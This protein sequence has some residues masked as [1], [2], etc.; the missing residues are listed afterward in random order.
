MELITPGIGLIFWQTVTF[1]LVLFLLGKFAWKPI[2]ASLSE[3]ED[4][5]EQALGAAA[6]AK[7]EM[8]LL[9]AENEN[10]L[11]QARLEKDKIIKE[12]QAVAVNIINDAKEKATSEG[13]RLIEGARMAIN[14]EKQAAMAD[15]KNQ[16]AAL[17]IQIA[18]RILK[19]ELSSENSQKALVSEYIKE[20]NLN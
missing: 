11:R 18:E 12:A 7:E 5:I 19:R 2:M 1:L 17:S 9:Q 15:V 3:R 16:A 10:L 14:T 8:M 13:N 20:A 4:T 6:K